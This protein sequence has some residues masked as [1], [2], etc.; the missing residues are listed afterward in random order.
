MIA[1]L[2]TEKKPPASRRLLAARAMI[3]AMFLPNSE[4]A[5]P[6]VAAWK[7]WLFIAWLGLT[8]AAYALSMAG[9][10]ASTSG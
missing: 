6:P 10:I 7:A 2:Q 1:P 8:L 3:A 4:H 5:A 9:L